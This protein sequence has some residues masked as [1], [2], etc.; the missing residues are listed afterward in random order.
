MDNLGFS[1]RLV[2]DTSTE[3]FSLTFIRTDKN[4]N[5]VVSASNVLDLINLFH[6]LSFGSPYSVRPGK[7][8]IP[9][10][11]RAL[12]DLWIEQYGIS[13]CKWMIKRCLEIQKGRGGEKILLFRGL[14]LYEHAAAG[15]YKNQHDKASKDKHDT[16]EKDQ[17]QHHETAWKEYRASKLNEATASLSGEKKNQLLEE[18]RK[19]VASA[20]PTLAGNQN[21]IRIGHEELMLKAIGA[22]TKE[23]FL[24]TAV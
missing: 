16:F 18:A 13:Q 17:H 4:K 7:R 14:S 24:A 20:T 23:E 9:D 15:D 21:L 22:K 19:S 10:P 8:Q 11:D 1:V 5:E 3:D 6:E 2:V 12:A